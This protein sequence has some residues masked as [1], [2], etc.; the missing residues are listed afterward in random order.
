SGS[1]WSFNVCM[2]L[3]QANFGQHFVKGFYS[4]AINRDWITDPLNHWVIKCHSL[5]CDSRT[6]IER[7]QRDF[8]VFSV[9]TYRDPREILRSAAGMFGYR[10]MD[11]IA[12][13]KLQLQFL[14]WQ[15]AFISVCLVPYMSIESSSEAVS[16]ISDFLGLGLSGALLVGLWEACGRDR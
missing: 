4:E 3:L 14:E 5:D 9:F 12:S 15:R 8:R 11:T 10:E 2:R 6:L 7:N 16:V 1:T 13:A